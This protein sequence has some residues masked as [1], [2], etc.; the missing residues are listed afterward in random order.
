[1]EVGEEIIDSLGEDSGPIYRVDGTEPVC[2]IEG[3]VGE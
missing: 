2:G 1:V 3:C